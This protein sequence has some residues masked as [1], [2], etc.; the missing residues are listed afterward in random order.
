MLIKLLKHQVSNQ[1]DKIKTLRK[2]KKIKGT[3]LYKYKT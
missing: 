3:N 1:N 2:Y